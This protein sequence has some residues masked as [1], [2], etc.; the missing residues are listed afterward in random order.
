MKILLVQLASMGDCLFVTAVARQIKKDDPSCHLTWLIGD[1]Y[2]SLLD[3]NPYIDEV[4][5]VPI[6][7]PADRFKMENFLSPIK[8]NYDKIII[9]DYYEDN[10]PN[11]YGPTRSAFFRGYDK[12]ITEIEPQIF[13]SDHEIANVKKFAQ[14]NR[15]QDY[16]S[17]LVECSPESFQ[18]PLTKELITSFA[19]KIVKINPKIKFIFSSKDKFE[20]SHP[21]FIDASSLTYR[22]NAELTKYCKLLIGAS[23]GITWLNT[24]NAAGKIPMIIIVYK[25]RKY[26]NGILSASVQEDFN[27]WGLSTENLIEFSDYNEQIL[28]DC[29]L[30]IVDKSFIDAKIKYPIASAK[31]KEEID[32]KCI[33]YVFKKAFDHVDIPSQKELFRFK[34]YKFK[35]L[36]LFSFSPKREYYKQKYIYYKTLAK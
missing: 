28:T 32:A 14:R 20:K 11:F 24:S 17:I 1:K 27:Y 23:S 12:E 15:L 36:Y 18:S 25:D 19:E 30:T 4:I 6:Q 16:F 13:L 21:N 2:K 22:E 7:N 33:R 9:T 8:A 35:L 3:N 10:Y 29:L 5:T 34:Y 26:F 31:T